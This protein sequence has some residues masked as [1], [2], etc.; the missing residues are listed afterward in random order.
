MDEM[1]MGAVRRTGVR[2]RTSF[3]GLLISKRANSTAYPCA[4]ERRLQRPG[5]ECSTWQPAIQLGFLR[6]Q[7]L[8]AIDAPQTF[9]ESPFHPA[10][11]PNAAAPNT[12]IRS[13][14]VTVL[15]RTFFRRLNTRMVTALWRR[16]G[17]QFRN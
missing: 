16:W 8:R 2:S 7:L 9:G 6:A 4:S 12:S 13:P 3:C 14:A 15:L 17:S 10:T 11:H 5:E 1:R